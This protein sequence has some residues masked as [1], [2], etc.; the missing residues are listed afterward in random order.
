[1]CSSKADEDQAVAALRRAKDAGFDD[2]HRL[3]TDPRLD[4]LRSRVDFPA[5]PGTAG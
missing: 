3:W 4:V 1:L 2:N 5:P